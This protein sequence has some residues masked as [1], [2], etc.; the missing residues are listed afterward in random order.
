MDFSN[1]KVSRSRPLTD[2]AK[3][4]AALTPILRGRGGQVRRALASGKRLLNLGCGPNI[5]PGFINLDYTWRPGLDLCWDLANGLPLPDG[6]IEGI[7]TEHCFEH[8]P[9]D[10]CKRTIAE[11]F[12]VLKPG[13]TFRVV[14]P[15][16]GL[17]LDLYQRS[18]AE[19]VDFPYVEAGKF[20]A[21]SVTP[22]MA[23][24]EMF[25]GH[26]HLF[27][28]DF[29]T[30]GKLLADAGFVSIE[31]KTFRQGRLASLLIDSQHRERESLYVEAL[32]G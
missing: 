7:Y 26:G 17:Y 30:M 18:K 3:V 6:Y 19:P 8:L 2:Y 32:K 14:V 12:R 25:R 9:L 23:V 28:Y 11:A 20:A 4:Q 21:G 10:L 31:R 13:G 27:A 5:A 16:G 29:A 1:T 24:N 22:M 15:D